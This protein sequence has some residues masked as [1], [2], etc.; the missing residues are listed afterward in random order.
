M[1]TTTTTTYGPNTALVERVIGQAKA[2]TPEQA[3]ALLAACGAT[4]D[5][6]WEGAWVAAQRVAR[7]AAHGIYRLN[8]RADAQEAIRVAAR[9][10]FW[11]HDCYH[12]ARD[13]ARDAAVACV[14]R[15][16]ITPEQ[17]DTLT[18]PWVAVF[19]P[20]EVTA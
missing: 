12:A 3:E 10:V 2:M 18:A 4:K 6:G 9:N 17:F 5:A 16:L 11:G 15:D 13:A 7:V 19:G 8:A 14:V 1:N 20:L